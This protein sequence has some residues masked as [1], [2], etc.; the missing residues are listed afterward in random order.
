MILKGF[1]NF[2][3][4]NTQA[5]GFKNAQNYLNLNKLYTYPV[6]LTHKEDLKAGLIDK[7]L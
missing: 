1:V 5:N 7:N 4:R 6:P 3:L 2:R